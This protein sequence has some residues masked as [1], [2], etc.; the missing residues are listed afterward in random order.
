[1]LVLE[2]VP[3]VLARALE[4]FRAPV[5]TL[6][7]HHHASISLLGAGG[8]EVALATYDAR[9]ATAARAEGVRLLEP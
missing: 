5:R 2:L 9:M 7:P 3:H 4:P 1:M 6:V 8:R